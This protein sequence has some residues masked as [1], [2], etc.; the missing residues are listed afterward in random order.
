MCML[1]A[2]ISSQAHELM[3]QFHL[4]ADRKVLVSAAGQVLCKTAQVQRSSS[5][6]RVVTQG[7]AKGTLS[8]GELETREGRVQVRT[9]S[10]RRAVRIRDDRPGVPWNARDLACDDSQQLTLGGP[11]STS[12]ARPNWAGSALGVL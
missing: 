7:P 5:C 11:F 1:I 12:D 9:A 4:G 2:K 10:R 3:L 8:L 6:P